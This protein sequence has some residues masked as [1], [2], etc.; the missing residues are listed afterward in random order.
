MMTNVTTA[1]GEFDVI[2]LTNEVPINRAGGVGTVVEHLCRGLQQ[3]D[4]RALSFLVAHGHGAEELERV[5]LDVPSAADHLHS[6]SHR[7]AVL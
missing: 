2:E 7:A 5:L 6:H 4:V 3:L 1:A